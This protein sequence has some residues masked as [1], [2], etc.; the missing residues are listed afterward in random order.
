MII[1]TW[2][3]FDVV[4]DNCSSWNETYAFEYYTNVYGLS[5]YVKNDIQ[6]SNFDI[7]LFSS[8]DVTYICLCV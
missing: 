6:V 5:K 4:S 1:Y 2:T 3:E 8:I 7:R